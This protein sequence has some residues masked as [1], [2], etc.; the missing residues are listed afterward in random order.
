[1][2]ADY[3]SGLQFAEHRIALS[4]VVTDNSQCI[5]CDANLRPAIPLCLNE[6]NLQGGLA[7]LDAAFHLAKGYDE[8]IEIML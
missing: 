8:H 3:F 6:C 5:F 4:Y 2:F 1:M 7:E